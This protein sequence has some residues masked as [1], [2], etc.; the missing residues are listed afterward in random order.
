MRVSDWPPEK[1][2]TSSRLA[3]PAA[4]TVPEPSN[5]PR[6]AHVSSPSTVTSAEPPSVAPCT[7]DDDPTV[8]APE[9]VSGASAS[10]RPSETIARSGPH[11]PPLIATVP[12]VS[13][14]VPA[15]VTAPVSVCVPE[16]KATVPSAVTGPATV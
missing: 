16:V 12:P 13:S 10:S 9:N 3:P 11:V 1:F 4:V 8:S 2:V 7:G 15:P 5:A 14:T 6:P